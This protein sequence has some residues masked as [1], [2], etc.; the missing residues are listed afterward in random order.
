M[1]EDPNSWADIHDETSHLD[2]TAIKL[3]DAFSMSPSQK[4]ISANILEKRLQI[5]WGPPVSIQI[6]KMN[7]SILSLTLKKGLG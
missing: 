1:I 4:D 6:Q 3:R 2:A 5:I 7:P